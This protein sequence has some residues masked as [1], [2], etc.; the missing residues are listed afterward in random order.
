M[1]EKEQRALA[2]AVLENPHLCIVSGDI[3]GTIRTF[4]VGAENLLGYKAEEVVGKRKAFSLYDPAEAKQ[5]AEELSRQYG[6]AVAEGRAGVIT[7]PTLTGQSEERV[8]TYIAKDG[9]RHKVLMS[10]SILRDDSGKM[11]GFL[12]IS[13]PLPKTNG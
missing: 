12:G 5:H 3:E 4:S 8:W 2:R 10:L 1:N 9:G 13:I 6:V 11:Q 7:G